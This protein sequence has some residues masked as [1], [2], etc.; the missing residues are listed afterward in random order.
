MPTPEMCVSQKAISTRPLFLFLG[1]VSGG[2]DRCE[3][4]LRTNRDWLKSYTV[5]EDHTGALILEV[6]EPIIHVFTGTQAEALEYAHKM[7]CAVP[8]DIE[9]WRYLGDY[10]WSFRLDAED[11]E[12]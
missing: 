8:P 5:R 1:Q 6:P 10:T 9:S 3:L 4:E 2:P 12:E 7:F 11:V